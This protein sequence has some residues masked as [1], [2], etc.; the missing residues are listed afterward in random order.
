MSFY[1]ANRQL[2]L[3]HNNLPATVCDSIDDRDSD[4]AVNVNS[5]GRVDHV[6]IP[7][8]STG[9]SHS[10]CVV[11]RVRN[12]PFCM[13]RGSCSIG[14]FHKSGSVAQRRFKV[15]QTTHGGQN[16]KK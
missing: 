10:M 8:K 12:K 11:C 3:P 14:S 15:L 9:Y 7:V 5:A 13:H 2:K 1:S 4:E 6:V 16:F